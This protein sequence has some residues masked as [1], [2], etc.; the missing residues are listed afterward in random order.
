MRRSAAKETKEIVQQ[1]VKKLNKK[2][3]LFFFKA[4]IGQQGVWEV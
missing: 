1:V 4:V 3:T 2:K